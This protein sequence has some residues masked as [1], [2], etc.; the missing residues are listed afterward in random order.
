MTIIK[1]KGNWPDNSSRLTYKRLMIPLAIVFLI[2]AGG[3]S[4]IFITIHKT[5]LNNSSRETLKIVSGKLEENL[6][7]Q[8]RAMATI[9]E[10]FISNASLRRILKVGNRQHLISKYGQIFLQLKRKF[11]ITHFYLHNQDRINILRIHKPERY[12]DIINRITILK[13]EQ[14]GNAASGVEL[15]PL[16]T[17][18]L[19]VV[20][21]VFEGST[22]I[23]Y[24]ELGKEI[25]DIL[26]D[27]HKILKVELAATIHKNLLNSKTWAEGMKM[28][29]RKGNWDLLS[30]DVLIYSSMTNL[31]A[32]LPFYIKEK[33][34]EH[35]TIT[36]K[37]DYN[38][39]SFHIMIKSLNDIY[40]RETGNLIIMK[41]IS[42]SLTHFR[43]LLAGT[44]GTALILFILLLSFFHFKLKDTDQTI[45]QQQAELKA[46][47]EELN[48]ILKFTQAGI[49]I[50][51]TDVN[52]ILFSNAAAAELLHS[53]PEAL[54]GRLY[55]DFVSKT[56]KEKYPI[57]DYRDTI[58]NAKKTLIRSDGSRCIVLESITSFQFQ[59]SECLLETFID[60]TELHDTQ[61]D[62]EAYLEE[63][64]KNRTVL[65]SMMEDAE[66]ARTETMEANLQLETI[67]KAVEASSDAISIATSKGSYFYLNKTFTDLFGYDLEDAGTL[68]RSALYAD[69]NVA[70]EILNIIM[71]G[72]SYHNDIEMV[73]RDGRQFP[74]EIHAD[75]VKDE[76]DNIIG[77]IDVYTD[78]TER[79]LAEKSLRESRD[80]FRSLVSNIPGVAYRC[81]LDKYWTVI[82]ISDDI[83]RISGYPA[84]D[85]INNAVRSYESI[86]HQ[87]DKEKV[88]QNVNMGIK[89]GRPWEFEYRIH[90]KDGGICWVYEKGR[91]VFNSNGEVEFLDG[92]TLDITDRKVTEELLATERRRL[93]D[94]LEGTNVGTWE[95]NIETNET[96]FN[97]RWANIIG[98]TLEEISPISIDTWVK[99]CHPDD[100]NKSNELLTKHFN[101]EIN[102]YE[103]EA[104]M[105]HKKGHWVWVLDRGKVSAWTKDGKPLFMSGTHQDITEQKQTEEDAIHASRAKSDFLAKMSHEIRT[106]LNAI[107]GMTDLS[108]M[109]VDEEERYK[110]L[111]IIKNSGNH[112]LHVINDILDFSKIESGKLLLEEK[113]FHFK[114]LFLS[115]EKIFHLETKRKN[116]TLTLELSKN[117]PVRVIADELRLRQ[118]MMNLISNSVKFTDKG[119]IIIK[120]GL[121]N[122]AQ[123]DQDYCTV[124]V[125][126]SDTGCG[127]APQMQDTIF[128]KF[129]QAE[130]GTSRKYGGT[131]LGLSIV[132][133]LIRLMNGEIFLKSES[134]K[135]SEFIFWIIL[136]RAKTAKATE[137]IDIIR[138]RKS[139]DPAEIKILL[140]EDNEINLALA[141]TVLKKLN[142]HVTAA[143]DGIEVLE[144]VRIGNYDLIFMDIEM[145]EMDGLEATRLIRAGHCG[146]RKSKIP[147][148]AMTAHALTDIRQECFNAGMNEY[149]TKPID[150][151]KIR[152]IIENTIEIQNKS[153]SN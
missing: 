108:L 50:I 15:G 36:A 46:G 83:K 119:G 20:S 24:I 116:I 70:K 89:S 133:E 65:I 64:D 94:I 148:I 90:H 55:H 18:T 6:E 42:K 99:F 150:I 151:L 142:F 95:W 13:A 32:K 30:K 146:S 81:K 53:S 5:N 74:V 77:L 147:I 76:Q 39:S 134:G 40:G 69:K 60:I 114:N 2:I 135:G 37:I 44:S 14:T 52:T 49:L 66:T 110:Y 62:R 144:S 153:K 34:H 132:R 129:E 145:P 27:I 105:R 3:F 22:L 80:Q 58:K 140:A 67:K 109:T 25:E 33:N 57:P 82:Y 92:F 112:L 43:Y 63:L 152:D 137:K 107:I 35:D 48:T 128:S 86:I 19:R 127:I 23:G 91:A 10:V 11:K 75:A 106:P 117:L 101:K 97:E 59:G 17:L 130:K 72:N 21:P 16:G 61:S 141:V 12:G 88:K 51:D 122:N 131:G 68:S 71:S 84:S 139:I 120:A 138:N 7:L 1:N 78:I 126:V 79:I 9:N 38:N 47:R 103:C 26:K 115:I 113:E 100:L 93:S 136:K 121:K 31:P 29:N 96:R 102:Y 8:S 125:S 4:I 143:R 56:E 85:F 104:R 98:Y 45:I 54:T 118:I 41:N 73:S 124:E 28:L 123:Q 111:S 149:I 87:K